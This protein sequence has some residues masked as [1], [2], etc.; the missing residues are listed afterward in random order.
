MY[1]A[2]LEDLGLLYKAIHQEFQGLNAI[3]DET[4]LGLW[5]F[6][7]QLTEANQDLLANKTKILIE[8]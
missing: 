8:K 3:Q 4:C 2:L 1:Y 6:F 5:L 7:T